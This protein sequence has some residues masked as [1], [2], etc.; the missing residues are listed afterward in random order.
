MTPHI[1][2]LCSGSNYFFY[3]EL[4]V[5]TDFNIV[6]KNFKF[7]SFLNFR[8]RRMHE[9]DISEYL[10][11]IEITCG[12]AGDGTLWLYD[13]GVAVSSAVHGEPTE[14]ISGKWVS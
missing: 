7:L 9:C 14:L 8:L 12:L 11:S 1:H 4:G 13:D 5:F 2:Y 10:S 6:T 3:I